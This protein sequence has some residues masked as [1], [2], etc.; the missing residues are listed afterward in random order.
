MNFANLLMIAR[1]RKHGLQRHMRV[2]SHT[3][4]AERLRL[5]QLALALPPKARALEIGSHL[6]SSALFLCAGL[7][8]KGGGL[9]CVDTWMNDAMTEQARDT[10][11]AF[12]ANTR[13]FASMITPVRKMSGDLTSD[14]IGGALDLVFIDGDH[15][16][17]GVRTDFLKVKDIVKIGGFVAFHD[18]RNCY[19]GIHVVLGEALSSGGWEIINMTDSLA[20]IVRLR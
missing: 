1:L 19:P 18:V 6:G 5:Y 2:F 7:H 9:V 16:E 10:Y 3:T 15:S 11:P 20:S 12:K 14:D 8:R 13:E 17:A 4:I